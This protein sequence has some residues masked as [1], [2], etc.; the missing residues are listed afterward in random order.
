MR[1]QVAFT[2]TFVKMG[3]AH[4]SCSFAF[5]ISA[6]KVYFHFSRF[7]CCTLSIDLH[8]CQPN[9]ARE[10]L[11]QNL[12]SSLRLGI[13]DRTTERA[14]Y[15]PQYLAA[16]LRVENASDALDIDTENPWIVCVASTIDFR[17]SLVGFGGLRARLFDRAVGSPADAFDL[18]CQQFRQRFQ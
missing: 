12:V 4:R 2:N 9:L 3:N 7:L 16:E 10:V 13:E 15:S 1:R 8:K 11:G 18:L 6:G 14:D 17:R 5:L